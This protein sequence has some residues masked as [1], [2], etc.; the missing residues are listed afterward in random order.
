[1]SITVF[2]AIM[3]I[4]LETSPPAPIPKSPPASS[5]PAI[6]FTAMYTSS[7]APFSRSN[8]SM[9]NHTGASI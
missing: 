1:M 5:V 3:S 8:T 2:S 9:K 4:F 6:S 7:E